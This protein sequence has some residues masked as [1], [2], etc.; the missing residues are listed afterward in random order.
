MS[1]NEMG[2]RFSSET[3]YATKK[4]VSKEL[5]IGIIDSIW[6]NIV[7]YRSSFSTNLNLKNVEHSAYIFV[8]TPYISKLV[9]QFETKLTKIVLQYARI[10]SEKQ[11]QALEVISYGKCLT[12]LGLKFN[13][14][15]S[16]YNYFRRL[17]LGDLSTISPKEIIFLNYLNTMRRVKQGGYGEI[18][19]DY[20]AKLYSL[21]S[22]NHELTSLYRSDDLIEMN[23]VVLVNSDF[24]AAKPNQI[25]PMM[26]LL[27]EFLNDDNYNV[28]VRALV[29]AYYIN[30]IIPF[31]LF[32]EEIAIAV[33]KSVFRIF[34]FGEVCVFINFE[35]LLR[36]NEELTNAILEVKRTNDITYY[37]DAALRLLSP[38]LDAI[39]NDLDLASLETVKEERFLPE[40]DY[41][42]GKL[43]VSEDS[44]EVPDCLQSS[45]NSDSI[46][47]VEFETTRDTAIQ[48][49]AIGFNERE[50]QL[51]EQHLIESDP[52]LKKTEAHFFAR[53]CTMGKFYTIDQFKKAL[54]TAYETAR[55]SMDGL[56]AYGYY[57]KEA[58]KNKF[59]YTPIRKKGLE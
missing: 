3:K 36:G 28:S 48:S 19:I 17:I 26:E 58:I 30:E 2:V 55:K 52:R 4:Q 11:V 10:V 49:F 53:H 39:I 6:S 24:K 51:L 21:I 20:I 29:A 33:L 23:R 40:E 31:E 41:I 13:Q 57:R 9:N 56:V 12:S 46:S 54:N 50:A 43:P 25:E 44:N 27:Y 14:V 42:I 1:A 34:G 59:I 47:E 18:N 38:Q 22:D 15:F 32:S 37:V 7:L 16:D 35:L 8:Q 5:N 45:R